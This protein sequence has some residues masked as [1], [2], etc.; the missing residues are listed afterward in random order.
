MS[1]LLVPTPKKWLPSRNLTYLLK[2]V[3]YH[4]FTCETWWLSIVFHSYVSLPEGSVP[5]YHPKRHSPSCRC[6]QVLPA[7]QSMGRI[8]IDPE[9]RGASAVRAEN[10]RIVELTITFPP[11][12]LGSWC[13]SEEK[14]TCWW[15]VW[16]RRLV[17]GTTLTSR[18]MIHVYQQVQFW[19]RRIKLYQTSILPIFFMT[20][21][22]LH[23]EAPWIQEQFLYLWV[24][25]ANLQWRTQCL[26]RFTCDFRPASWMIWVG[27]PNSMV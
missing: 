23:S 22:W 9:D 26:G 14:K 7:H 13:F 25:Q 19:G 6:H 15:N 18:K 2:M 21:C 17:V 4:W 11:P 5:M 10:P 3:I 1:Y 16:K 24:H 12:A 8:S 20:P 27:R